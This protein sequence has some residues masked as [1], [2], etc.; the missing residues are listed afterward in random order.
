MDYGNYNIARF[1]WEPA[2]II[3]TIF[4]FIVLLGTLIGITYPLWSIKVVIVGIVVFC[5]LFVTFLYCPV[6][7][8]ID[9]KT[10]IIKRVK[11]KLKIPIA[12]IET[13]TPIDKSEI[14]SSIRVFGSG[15]LFGYLGVFRSS[16]RGTFYMY[17]TELS[18]L[19]MIKTP[20][21]SYVICCRN[22]LLIQALKQ[23]LSQP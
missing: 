9:D 8:Q 3:I 21:R 10:L 15:G 17:V 11:G 5:P 16:R 20:T 23:Q 6:Y 19:Y 12:E 7:L 13:I 18:N 4:V 1:H 2:V 22:Q 14:T